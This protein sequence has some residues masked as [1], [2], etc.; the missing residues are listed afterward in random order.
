LQLQRSGGGPA[1]RHQ[2][3]STCRFGQVVAQWCGNCSGGFCDWCMIDN[4]GNGNCDDI[5]IDP[6][7]GSFICQ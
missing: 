6:E 4:D 1:E 7:D 5:I 2:L 3:T